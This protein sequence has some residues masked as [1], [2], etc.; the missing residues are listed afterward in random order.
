M[1]ENIPFWIKLI[2]FQSTD[3]VWMVASGIQLGHMN[4]SGLGQYGSN[5]STCPST[6]VATGSVLL[7]AASYE[8]TDISVRPTKTSISSVT[9]SFQT[10]FSLQ[11][12]SATSTEIAL[13]HCK[14]KNKL[15]LSFVSLMINLMA[16]VGVR[17]ESDSSCR[18]TGA[19]QTIVRSNEEVKIES[20]GMASV[21]YQLWNGHLVL[22]SVCNLWVLLFLVRI[23]SKLLWISQQ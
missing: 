15:T 2:H 12:R 5:K 16:C 6:R 13:R 23:S 4:G 1:L 18:P 10:S 3:F 22:T 8:N 20:F 14:S 17:A 11:P 7:P 19:V 21:I 9:S